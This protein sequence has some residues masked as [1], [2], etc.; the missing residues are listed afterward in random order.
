MD[1]FLHQLREQPSAEFAQSLR[2]R[3]HE[4]ERVARRRAAQTAVLRVAGASIAALSLLVALNVRA[5]ARRPSINLSNEQ[6]S[7]ASALLLPVTDAQRNLPAEPVAWTAMDAT[8]YAPPTPI[9]HH[10]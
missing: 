1:D 6:T 8:L 9:S 5:P 7:S 2:A 10:H 3:L 4:A